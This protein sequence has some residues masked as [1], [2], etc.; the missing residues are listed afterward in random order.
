MA[1]YLDIISG[2]MKGIGYFA[3]LW[4]IMPALLLFLP[5]QTTLLS[6]SRHVVSFIDR[7]NFTI[8]ECVKWALPL[9]VLSVAISVFA[10]SLFGLSWTKLS[11]SAQY[12]HATAFMLGAAMTLLMNEHVRVDIFQS[13][14]SRPR[15]ALVDFIGFYVGLMPVCLL[16]IWSSNSFVGLSWSIFEGSPE[17]DGI[18]AVFLLKTLIPAFAILMLAQGLSIALRA[19]MVMRGLKEPKRIIAMTDLFPAL[20]ERIR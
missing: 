15:K 1:S 2:A 9:L 17:T 7:L 5:R 16:L 8:G 13:R 19:V 11:E 20:E 3:L 12:F 6:I 4:L 18:K 10:L 14:L